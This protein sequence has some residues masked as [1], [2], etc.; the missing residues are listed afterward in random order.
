MSRVKK[1]DDGTITIAL[2]FP[3]DTGKKIIDSL[4]LRSECTVADLEAMDRAKGR[5]V[6]Q[7]KLMIAELSILSDKD[8]GISL[9]N[10]RKLRSVDY[11][12][13]AQEVGKIIGGEDESEGAS[14]DGAELGK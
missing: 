14:E 11:L 12:V 9:G 13:I 1:N 7:T 5:E 8:F 3:V 10:V 4:T 6:E 2:K